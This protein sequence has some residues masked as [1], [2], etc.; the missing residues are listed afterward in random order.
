M[1]KAAL[2]LMRSGAKPRIPVS[3]TATYATDGPSLVHW[4]LMNAALMASSVSVPKLICM[5]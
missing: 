4:L 5:L 3:P 2:Q 1:D